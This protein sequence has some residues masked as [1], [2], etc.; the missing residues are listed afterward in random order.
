MNC[1]DGK[2]VLS[3][4]HLKTL[5]RH[6]GLSQE[7][8]AHRLSEEKL[9]MSIATVK[10]AETGR[11][12][13]YSTAYKL[14]KFYNV[15]VIELI[16]KNSDFK[17]KTPSNFD[18]DPAWGQK[19]SSKPDQILSVLKSMVT[20]ESA[21]FIVSIFTEETNK[22]TKL[23]QNFKNY[24]LSLKHSVYFISDNS[25]ISQMKKKLISQLSLHDQYS[26]IPDDSLILNNYPGHKNSSKHII[27]CVDSYDN[28]KHDIIEIFKVINNSNHSIMFLFSTHI[29]NRKLPDEWDLTHSDFLM[30]SF[31]LYT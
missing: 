7:N 8:L 17:N 3:N 11:F 19:C 28:N 10:R 13:N 9:Y 12:V 6:C 4:R 24:A 15:K 29:K 26:D 31:S 18:S 14:A 30:A 21:S 16:A 25:N 2:V 5:R 23:L 20:L 27:I 22:K 1:S